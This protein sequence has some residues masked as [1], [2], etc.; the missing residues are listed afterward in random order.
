MFRKH[1][2]FLLAKIMNKVLSDL[3]DHLLAHRDSILNEWL[4]IVQ[5]S[6][7][8]ASANHLDKANLVD[9]LPETF[10]NIA[11]SLKAPSADRDISA[12]SRAGRRHGRFRW[13]Q[14][15][16]LEEV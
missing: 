11:A 7:D 2:L 6:P 13:R 12:V 10:E 15:Y 4:Q 5:R 8:I 14:G 16:R 1:G 3:A 9:H